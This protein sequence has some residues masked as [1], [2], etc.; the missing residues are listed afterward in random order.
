MQLL[1]I[2]LASGTRVVLVAQALVAVCNIDANTFIKEMETFRY[3]LLTLN[4]TRVSKV[5]SKTRIALT[6]GHFDLGA[7]TKHT[8]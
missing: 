5:T 2:D 3:V 4:E 1:N 8:T 7:T 6:S